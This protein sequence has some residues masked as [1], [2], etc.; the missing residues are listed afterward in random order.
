[1]HDFKGIIRAART[2]LM[3]AAIASPAAAAVLALASLH[4]AM[5]A[6][7]GGSEEQA[8]RI[9]VLSDVHY[10]TKSRDP[11]ERRE[12]M[13][14][15]RAAAAEISSWEDADL[16]VFTGDMVEKYATQAEYAMARDFAMSVRHPKAFVAGNHEIVY[17]EIPGDHGIERRAG[18]LERLIH[19]RLFEKTFGPLYYTKRLGGYLLVFL[20]PDTTDAA[21]VPDGDDEPY[22]GELSPREVA[23][24]KATLEANPDTPTLVFCHTPLEGSFLRS[25]PGNGERNFT[26][27]AGTIRQ[28]LTQNPQV[29]LWVSGHTHT[30]PRSASYSSA[31]NRQSGAAVV[32]IHN[33]AWEGDEIWTNSIFLYKDKV[34][35]RTWS[36]KDHRWLD[37]LDRSYAVL[38][39]GERKALMSLASIRPRRADGTAP[40]QDGGS[41]IAQNLAQ[42]AAQPLSRAGGR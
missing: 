2:A 10:G 13:A 23:W 16:C 41:L 21:Y 15:K 4:P 40:S 26:Q 17:S 36:H 1:M 39:T 32:D 35:V 5:A 33:P 12:R 14:R 28:I 11:V 34:E 25:Y 6:E 18:P 19:L 42:G 8:R 31:V 7:Q 20:A 38:A 37:P 22:A 27:P 3:A 9:V 29:M 24:F 30:S